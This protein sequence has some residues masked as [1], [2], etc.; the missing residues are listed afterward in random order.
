M[1]ERTLCRQQMA[2][3][4]MK[5]YREVIQSVPQGTTQTELYEMVVAHPAPRFY[6]DPRMAHI[7]LS[8]MM[9]GDYKELEKLKPLKRKMYQDLFDVVMRLSQKSHYWGKSLYYILKDAVLEPAPQFYI[10]NDRMRLIWKEKSKEERQARMRR[11]EK[12]NN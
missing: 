3:D 10:S 7:R 11:Y 8:P 2:S 4:L 12:R 1:R 5:I 9:R 6:I